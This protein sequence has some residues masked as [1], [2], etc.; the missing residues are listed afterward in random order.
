[1]VVFVTDA[2]LLVI[3]DAGKPSELRAKAGDITWAGA[4]RHRE[5]NLA[6]APFEVVVVEV[7]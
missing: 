4:S 6:D 3:D 2:H 5:E 1:V 7:K